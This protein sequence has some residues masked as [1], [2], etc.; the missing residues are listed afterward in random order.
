MVQDI[1]FHWQ[2]SNNTPHRDSLSNPPLWETLSRHLVARFVL[3]ASAYCSRCEALSL[4]LSW[5]ERPK[6][7]SAELWRKVVVGATHGASMSTF[8][9]TVH[10]LGAHC[11]QKSPSAR[12]VRAKRR[13][14]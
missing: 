3:I 12:I 9:L 11:S 8:Q 1:I 10:Q 2:P 14:G 5:R 13:A 4:S 7:F 6:D